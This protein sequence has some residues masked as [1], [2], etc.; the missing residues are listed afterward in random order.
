MK[1]LCLLLLATSLFIGGCAKEVSPWQD[2]PSPKVLASFPPLASIALNVVGAE[3]SV[4]S[5][6]TTSGVHFHGD[7]STR[8]IQ[9]ARE[10]DVIFANGLNL[11]DRFLKKIK[12][13]AGNKNWFVVELGSKLPKKLLLEGECG[14]DHA[15][16]EVHDHPTDPHVWL[17]PVNAKLFAGQMAKTLTDFK[18]PNDKIAANLLTY[19]GKLDELLAYGENLLKDKKDRKF[20]SFHDSLQYFVRDF[21]LEIA[22]VIEIEPGVEPG[23]KQM[24]ELIDACIKNRVRVIAVEPQ[25]TAKNAAT[26]IR[27]ELLH[28]GID[29][30][31]VEIDPL[32]TASEITPNLYIDTM[33]KNLENLAEAL[34]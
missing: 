20:V 22:G 19:L 17:S 33:K 15:A 5:L 7:P 31:F 24:G 11:E 34:K 32:E 4:L 18:V 6:F 30:V 9:L 13:P 23:A 12:A 10:A 16:G 3:G 2:K 1:P 14:H 8:E 29:A 26:T 25:F 28:H 27:N 21:K